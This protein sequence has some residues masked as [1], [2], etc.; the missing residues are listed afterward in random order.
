MPIPS[1][2]FFNAVATLTARLFTPDVAEVVL[3]RGSRKLAGPCRLWRAR[4]F[5]CDRL[6]AFLS[7]MVV[8]AVVAVMAAAATATAAVLVDDFVAALVRFVL[9]I[10]VF[11]LRGR[12]RG[13]RKKEL[14]LFGNRQRG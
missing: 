5:L 10:G 8:A 13:R 1:S 11:F 4:L 7:A 2:I 14:W 6:R 12:E 3:C 9:F